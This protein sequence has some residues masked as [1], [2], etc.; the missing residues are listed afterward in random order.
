MSI[1]QTIQYIKYLDRY[2]KIKVILEILKLL[3]KL[4][5]SR[6]I[7]C[8][9][10]EELTGYIYIKAT[11]TLKIIKLLI[12]IKFF[13]V[14]QVERSLTPIKKHDANKSSDSIDVKET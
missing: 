6:N 4:I 3:N 14:A 5:Q 2:I 8:V 1:S 10:M 7:N 9:Q 13:L 12:L 11:I